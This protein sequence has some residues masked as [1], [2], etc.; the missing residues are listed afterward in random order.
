LYFPRS[1]RNIV[2]AKL[3]RSALSP[4][5]LDILRLIVKGLSN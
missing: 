3:S 2:P 5:E 4:R 1:I